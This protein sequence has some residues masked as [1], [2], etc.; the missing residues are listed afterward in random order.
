[1]TVTALARLAWRRPW[2]L[3]AA[4]LALVAAGGLAGRTV[5]SH[6]GSGGFG[7][8]SFESAVADTR[9]QR[10]T[11]QDPFERVLVL[12]RTPQGAATPAGRAGI[13][14]AVDRLTGLLGA[15]PIVVPGLPGTRRLVASDGR[16][17]LLVLPGVSGPDAR[18]LERELRGDPRLLVGG[19]QVV[20]EQVNRILEHDLRRAELVALPLVFVLSLL[21][22][23]GLVAALLPPLVGLVAIA[24]AL[25]GLRVAATW[26]NI[27][28]YAL[29]VVVG[30]CLGLA[31]DYTL[32]LVSRYREELARLGPGP[33]AVERTLATA[34]RTVVFSAATVAA[35]LASLAVFPLGF[36]RSMAVGGALAATLAAAVA[37]LVLPALLGR[38]GPGVNALSPGPLRR[39]VAATAR[40]S[41]RGFWQRLAHAVMRRPLLVALATGGAL[42]ALGVPFLRIAFTTVDAS[43]LPRGESARDVAE[44]LRSSYSPELAAPVYVVASA[45]AGAATAT[46]RYAARIR[47]LPGRPGVGAPEY[48][49]RGTWRIDVGAATRRDG[50]RAVHGIR[51]LHAPWPVAVGGRD[52]FLVDQKAS[53]AAH[54][55]WA[56]GLAVAA[57]LVALFLLTGSVVL[58][59]KAVLLNLL[60]LAAVFGALVLVFQDG[61][62][63]GLLDFTRQGA[64]N[65]TQPILVAAF[66]FG[67]STDYGIFLL[68]RIKEARDAGAD[69]RGAI[70]EGLERT[71]R[72]VTAAALLFVVA[73]GA[74]ASSRIVELKEVG[75]GTALA[76][77]LDA[78]VVRALLVPSLM[79]L[80]GRRN[81]WAP[82]PL[83][84]LHERLDLRER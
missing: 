64:I 47:L 49:G 68:T 21:V 65:T 30:T 5:V 61:H 8:D 4:A 60:T 48:L 46:A 28:V 12:V 66:A 75:F 24:G 58:P 34:G 35:A 78:T 27:S 16:S 83:R 42:V 1:M 29:N 71:G 79:V 76:V 22:F 84:R 50:E 56:V 73:I 74:F 17:A 36:L 26:M 32:L 77:A 52:A 18:L 25:L 3:L 23:G 20:A 51:S 63:G 57:T 45:P 38:L 69:D 7:T 40:P 41:E 33:A 19:S 6:L 53:L 67:L 39:R 15:R 44:T 13:A 59:I 11:G 10:A 55:P 70:A 14:A 54:I 31:I 43:A 82:G 9:L 37:L 62:L 80:L 72:I 2:P 81:W